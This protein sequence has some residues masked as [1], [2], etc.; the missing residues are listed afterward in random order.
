MEY[1]VMERRNA[2]GGMATY[3]APGVVSE[4]DAARVHHPDIRV[5][6]TAD[7]EAVGLGPGC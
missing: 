6:Q 5:T 7:G 3:H 1:G 4:G 2:G